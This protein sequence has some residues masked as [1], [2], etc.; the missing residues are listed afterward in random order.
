[1]GIMATGI[2]AGGLVIAPFVGGY[3]IPNFGWSTS[4]IVSALLTWVITIPLAL[5]ILKAKPAD[6][7]LYPDGVDSVEAETSAKASPS[8]SGGLTPK[9]ALATSAFW[10]I[11]VTLVISSFSQ[12][13][14]I[15]NQ[16]PYLEDVGFPVVTAAA[17][18]GTIGLGSLIGKFGF[19]WLC[20][21]IPPKYAYSIGLGLMLVGT[22][23]LMDVGPSSP[24]AT[25]WLYAIIMGLGVG[26]WLPTSSLLTSTNFGLVSYGAI[27]GLINGFHGIGAAMGPM[28]VGYIYDITGTYDRAF[29]IALALLAV[30]I[31]T[32]LAVRHPKSP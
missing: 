13:G 29:I 23:M 9:M 24:P 31:A 17:A 16:V 15:Q 26:S 8:A 2:G 27:W 30:S 32:I 28:V 21:Q 20:D 3:L 6:M 4:Y 19:G 10:L 18:L 14:I 11:T 1:M 7:G 5:F 25:I 22:F 12:L